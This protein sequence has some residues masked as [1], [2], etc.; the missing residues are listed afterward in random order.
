MELLDRYIEQN[1]SGCIGHLRE[2][3]RFPSVAGEPQAGMPFGRDVNACL[4][5][6]LEIA[7]ELGFTVKNLDGY[8]G[9]AEYGEGEEYV[10]VLGHLDVVPEGEGWRHPPYAAE[11]EDSRIYGRGTTDD[12]G[13][14]VAA[15]YGLKAIRDAGLPFRRKVRIIFG[16]NEESGCGDMPYYMSHEKPPVYGFTPDAEFPAI[17]SEK[18]A[19]FLE[20]TKDINLQKI[21]SVTG[22][23]APNSVPATCRALLDMEYTEVSSRLDA[24]VKETGVK[25]TCEKTDAG[26]LLYSEG[27]AAHGSKPELGRNAVMQ[28]LGFL[29]KLQDIELINFLNV[30]IGMDSNGAGLGL[31]MPDEA[32]DLTL[33]VGMI[34]AANGRL[35]LTLD[36]RYPGKYHEKDVL[37]RLQKAF[38]EQGVTIHTKLAMPAVYFP[39]DH[40]LIRTL[41]GVYEKFTGRKEEPLAIG[42]G[43]YAKYVP[44]L[45]AFGPLLPDRD[46]LNHMAN[47]YIEAK[48]LLLLTKIYGAAIYAL[49]N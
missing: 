27:H 9:Y 12:K 44:N 45:V 26:V 13:P 25:I 4:T 21:K 43:T 49:A 33:N 32:G 36:I 10:A 18:G 8:C 17:Y 22:G 7:K 47:E 15:L 35:K 23:V 38:L 48:E 19:L 11:M 1:A 28:M 42:G 6:A 24:F 39:K 29:E 14:I 31:A 46:D 2:L 3:I 20:I 41:M 16:C 30:H 37:D 34:E 40:F 5:R